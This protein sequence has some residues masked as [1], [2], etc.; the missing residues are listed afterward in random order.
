GLPADDISALLP[1][2]GGGVWIGTG[3]A[4]LYRWAAGRLTA[5]TE[6]EGL[7]DGNISALHEDRAGALWIGSSQGLS[8]LQ[9]GRITAWTSA[10]GLPDSAIVSI[11][12]GT[13][14]ALWLGTAGSGLLRFQAGRVGRLTTRQ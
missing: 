4:G 5:Y 10:A 9:D 11:L 14:G 6:K 13:G 1:A 8:R 3:G 12:E 7:P 2:R